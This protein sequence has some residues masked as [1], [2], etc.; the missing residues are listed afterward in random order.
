MVHVIHAKLATGGNSVIINVLLDVNLNVLKK[1]VCVGGV[2]M[3][4]M[5]VN[6]LIHVMITVFLVWIRINV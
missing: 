5:V 3:G 2:R 1:Q 6:A 4:G